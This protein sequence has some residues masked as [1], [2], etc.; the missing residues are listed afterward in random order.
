[1]NIDNFQVE[2]WM[3]R[4]ENDCLY[5]LA[6]TCAASLT[7][8][9][10]LD[11]V[12]DKER[13]IHDILQLKL[14]YGPIEGSHQLKQGILKLYQSGDDDQIAITHG[15]IN[16]NELVL[17]TLLKS[18]DHIITMK[19]TYQ[20]LYSLPQSFGVTVDFVE[21]DEEKNWQPDICD[22]QKRVKENTKMICLVA[23]NNPTGTSF[24]KLFLTQLI[25]I[26][27]DKGIYIFCDEA[28]RG[29]GE[30]EISISDIYDKGIS[31][32]GISKILSTAG[33][34]IGWIKTQDK[35][36]IKQINERRDYHIISS[37]ALNDYL[38]VQVFQNYETIIARNK[39]NI[40]KN[41]LFIK[42]WLK[43]NP[44]VTCVLP[45]NGTVCF[46]KYHLDMKSEQLSQKLQKET[47]VFFVPGSCFDYEYHLRFGIANDHEIV[48]KGLNLFGEW[49][50]K[51]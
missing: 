1:M 43:D 25:E 40:E 12:D 49:L 7:M 47:G 51:Q 31:T 14:D 46:L 16:A 39:K 23:P 6:D 8:E 5:N 24:D 26:C 44:L 35:S 10:L 41:K 18:G 2:S 4:H 29:L 22:F 34:R 9:E 27:Q 11:M 32:S 33:L 36:L 13:C 45:Q 15:C 19:P 37:G 30:N 20:Q 38:A 3:T 17:M 42:S 48:K 28:Y 50:K 21:L